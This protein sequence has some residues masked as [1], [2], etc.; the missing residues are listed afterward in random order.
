MGADQNKRF[1][2]GV[3]EVYGV[4]VLC[5]EQSALLCAEVSKVVGEVGP[6]DLVI[7]N[8]DAR[9]HVTLLHFACN[10]LQAKQMW[11]EIEPVNTEMTL[12]TTGLHASGWGTGVVVHLGITM[13]SQLR[14]LHDRLCAAAN[15]LKIPLVS[16]HGVEYEAH[17]TLGFWVDG[18]D[19]SDQLEE[20]ILP[21]NVS[22]PLC[23][24]SIG[25]HGTVA[26]VLMP[27]SVS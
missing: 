13:T 17:I 26:D 20:I 12:A 24:V 7:N 27:I 14:S 16:K 4:V 15:E 9:P 22:G 19:H 2:Y 1:T 18:Q 5:D 8:D 6:S 10:R 25:A 21:D 3:D 23:L 11:S